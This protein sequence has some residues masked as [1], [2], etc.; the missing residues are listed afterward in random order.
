VELKLQVGQQEDYLILILVH[1]ILYSQLL[2][3]I[4]ALLGQQVEHYQQLHLE[5][6]V[7]ELKQQDYFLQ[8]QLMVVPIL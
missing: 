6:E 1:Q 2:M 3:N 5:Q 8:E 4:M 7:R